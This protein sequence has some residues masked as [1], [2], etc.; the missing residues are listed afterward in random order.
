MFQIK[1]CGIK[2]IK[3]LLPLSLRVAVISVS[4]KAK[5]KSLRI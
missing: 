4:Y 5:V 2:D 1:R 3:K